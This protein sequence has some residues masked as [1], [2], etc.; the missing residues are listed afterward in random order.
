MDEKLYFQDE[1]GAEL[2]YR[3]QSALEIYHLLLLLGIK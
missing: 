3:C 2:A 1:D